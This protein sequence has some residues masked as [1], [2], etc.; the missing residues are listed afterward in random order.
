MINYSGPLYARHPDIVRDYPLYKLAVWNNT[1]NAHN[2]WPIE[3]WDYNYIQNK[4]TKYMHEVMHRPN[5]IEDDQ[6]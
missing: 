3:R 6:W 4:I 5:Q 1:A 2:L